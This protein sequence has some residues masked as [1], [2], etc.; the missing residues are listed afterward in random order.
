M[1]LSDGSEALLEKECRFGK[2]LGFDGKSLIH[3][4]QVD[5]ANLVFSP[6]EKDIL[7]ANDIIRT[8]AVAEAANKGVCTL[9]GR[10]IEKLHVDAAK[11][12]VARFEHIQHRRN[13]SKDPSSS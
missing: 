4:K 13:Q 8:F 10:L 5:I 1:D 9:Y 12:V 3:P 6:S 7:H 2:E 11:A